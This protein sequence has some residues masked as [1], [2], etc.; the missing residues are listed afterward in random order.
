MIP[1]RIHR[2]FTKSNMDLLQAKKKMQY[3]ETIH[4][5]VQELAKG[6]PIA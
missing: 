1:H 6:A 2:R 3:I 4:I 5:A